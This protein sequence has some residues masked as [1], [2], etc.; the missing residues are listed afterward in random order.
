MS[1]APPPAEDA[2]DEIMTAAPWDIPLPFGAAD[3]S[4]DGY[5]DEAGEAAPARTRGSPPSGTGCRG[6]CATPGCSSR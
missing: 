3:L 4:G 6:S 2:E 5:G 1:E